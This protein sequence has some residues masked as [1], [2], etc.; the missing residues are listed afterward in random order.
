[1]RNLDVSRAF[2]FKRN[3]TVVAAELRIRIHENCHNMSI[4]DV[5]ERVTVGDD[6]DLV[7]LAW[8]D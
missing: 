7:P 4:D 2:D 8:L 1:M 5:D 3:Y 6:L